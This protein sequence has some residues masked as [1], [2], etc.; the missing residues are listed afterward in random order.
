MLGIL[1]ILSLLGIVATQEDPYRLPPN[2]NVIHQDIDLV[3]P[4]ESFTENSSDYSGSVAI[5]FQLTVETNEVKLHA[6]SNIEL[7]TIQLDDNDELPK[8]Q[9]FVNTTTDIL[10]L[11][12]FDNLLVEENYTLHITF[13]A[14]LLEGGG[15]YKVSYKDHNGET[16]YIA[17]TQFQSTNARNAFPCFDEP[18]YKSTFAYRLT[19]P[20]GLNAWTNT[21]STLNSTLEN[22]LV[23]TEFDVTPRMSAYLVAFT[24][25]TYTCTEGDLEGSSEYKLRVCSRVDA[26][27]KRRWALSLT[28]DVVNFHNQYTG[29]NYTQSLSKLDQMAVPGKS[30]AMENW[31]LVIYGESVLLYDNAVQTVAQ[32][33]SIA[34]IIAHELTHQWFGNLITC[35]W[36]SE[37]FLN[38]GFARLF[39][40]YIVDD[41]LPSYEMEMQ[42]VVKIV[43]TMLVTDGYLNVPALRTNA[44]TQSEASDTFGSY[45]Y[46][47]GASVLRMIEHIVGRDTFKLGIRKYIANNSYEPV[48]PQDLW[49]A[50]EAVLENEDLSLPKNVTLSEVVDSWINKGGY[51]VLNVSLTN[52]DLIISQQRFLYEGAETEET[53]WYVPVSYTISS[54]N[55]N[56][57]DTTPRGWVT[58][59]KDLVISNFTEDNDWI[60]VN[61]QQTGF[62]HVNY[63]QTLWQNL[64]SALKQSNFSGIHEVNRAQMV[65]DAHMLAR[66]GL[67][68]FGEVLQ[69]VEFLEHDVSYIS[70]YPA[71][72]LFNY[73]LQK[74][75]S[76]TT[77]G[78]ALAS[79][80]LRLIKAVAASVPLDEIDEDNHVYT[81]KQVLID[82]YACKYGNEA[83]I[84]QAKDAFAAYKTTFKRPNL[85]VRSIV[86]CNALRYSDDALTDW[87]FLYSQYQNLS[88]SSDSSYIW[89]ALGC[90]KDAEIL[91]LFLGKI[92]ESDD[93]L[94]PE[95]F[96]SIF[97]T[98]F[99]GNE[100][101]VNTALDYFLENY[102]AI[103]KIFSENGLDAGNIFSEVAS[104]L[105]QGSQ[106]EKVEAFLATEGLNEKLVTSIKSA[107]ETANANQELVNLYK[108]SILE[109]LGVHEDEDNSSVPQGH[110]ASTI[111]A[112]VTSLIMVLLHIC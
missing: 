109:Y 81:L 110:G 95:S 16:Q 70:W 69:I 66:A 1:V 80:F 61:N 79:H 38:E 27:E 17:T 67:L 72:T 63:D 75:G 18:T 96:I 93:V 48:E 35:K 21:P 99:S 36:W 15:F 112:V 105:T 88:V 32:K 26:E 2:Y 3:V 82:N 37:T 13:N 102:E 14:Q 42:F 20:E 62:Y 60:V 68:T 77:L 87:E 92:L 91:R 54:S 53:K 59:I 58:P 34:E 4:A 71:V 5:Q 19:Y 78:A 25:S 43:Q 55:D 22:G 83:C 46:S 29:I 28:A 6:S 103:L 50:L 31:G 30:G 76:T 24:I 39:Q 104:Y 101:G 8:E 65:D 52:G 44:S 51:P 49:D 12:F 45:S 90:T 56:N 41:I 11:T 97:S 89:S 47:K 10:T 108:E 111:G 40:Y 106:L 7:L 57:Q 100:E 73:L 9:Y 33:Q 98:I 23:R 84:S 85:N 107:L 86:Y 74:T 64:A 94:L